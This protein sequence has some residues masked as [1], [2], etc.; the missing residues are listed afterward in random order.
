LPAFRIPARPQ[1]PA[2][3]EPATGG[4]RD[5]RAA[6]GAVVRSLGLARLVD[7][8]RPFDGHRPGALDSEVVRAVRAAGLEYMW[9]K[10]SFG[11]SAPVLC[12]ATFLALPFTA[13]N[14]DGW[15]PFYTLGR[16]ADLHR[17]ERRLLRAGRPGW[18]AGTI[19]SPLFALSGEVWEHG[20][21]LHE[22]AR[23]ATAG[24]RSGRLVNVRPGVVARYARL[25]HERS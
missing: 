7:E 3:G 10:T 11:T 6:A 17:A 5:P 18:L 12:D 23:S 21:R 24:G 2:G 19:D 13:G 16:A 20:A 14:W 4:G 1:A 22:I 15:S 25:L 8:R 9:T